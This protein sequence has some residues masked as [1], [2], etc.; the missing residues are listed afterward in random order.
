MEVLYKFKKQL[1]TCGVPL[2]KN[3]NGKTNIKKTNLLLICP[4]SGQKIIARVNYKI[5]CT[6]CKKK[7]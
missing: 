4:M 5:K 3:K 7:K 6:I 2:L 1:N